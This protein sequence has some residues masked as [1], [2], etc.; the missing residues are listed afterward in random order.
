MESIGER[1]KQAR[2]A[3]HISVEEAAHATKIRPGHIFDLERDEYSN[4]PNLA[5]AKAFLAHYAR[6][7]EVDI[8]THLHSFETATPIGVSDYEYLAQAPKAGAIPVRHERSWLPTIALLLAGAFILGGA[9]FSYFAINFQRL[10]DLDRLANR[11]GQE[12]TTPADT[13]TP[14]PASALRTPPPAPNFSP[15]TPP[16]AATTAATTA[17]QPPAPVPP[18]GATPT[19]ARFA[20]RPGVPPSATPP[21]VEPEVRKAEPADAGPTAV[22]TPPPIP[23]PTTTSPGAKNVVL[24]PVRKTWVRVVAGPPGGQPVFED[25]LYPDARPLKFHGQQFT[26]EMTDP[27]GV[28]IFRDGTPIPYTPPGIRIE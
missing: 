3:R 15:A 7:L 1:L 23:P 26:I 24:Q 14:P 11:S 5:Y 4:F 8:A 12:G 18:F 10:G 16:P 20:D 2:L 13:A 17:V 9:V 21:I 19:P 6:F 27:G 25:W 22:A 28:M